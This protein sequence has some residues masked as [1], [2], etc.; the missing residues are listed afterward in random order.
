MQHKKLNHRL[1]HGRQ[2]GRQTD[3]HRQQTNANKAQTLNY[4][5][6][7]ISLIFAEKHKTNERSMQAD[8]TLTI[9]T[10]I[11]VHTAPYLVL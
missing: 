9:N 7:I 3:R 5:H 8:N 11:I 6:L 10:T 4:T 1:H 2:T